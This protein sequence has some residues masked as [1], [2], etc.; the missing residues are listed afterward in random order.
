MIMVEGS[1][2]NRMEES[3]RSQE[4]GS[5]MC[6]C[7]IAIMHQK[8]GETTRPTTAPSQVSYTDFRREPGNQL[9]T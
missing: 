9:G 8:G 7:W 5:I 1:F 3:R 4:I 2:F 6:C